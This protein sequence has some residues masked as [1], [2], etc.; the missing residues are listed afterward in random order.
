MLVGLVELA[1]VSG[2]VGLC[3]IVLVV[4]FGWWAIRTRWVWS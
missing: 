1:W 4:E 2:L 3:S